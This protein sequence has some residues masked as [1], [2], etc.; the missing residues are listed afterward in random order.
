ML[1]EVH[2]ES[3]VTFARLHGDLDLGSADA[4]RD[5]LDDLSASPTQHIV[6][7]LCDVS[8]VDVMSLSVILGTAD[9]LRES[10]RQLA[11][12]GASASI[13]RLCKVL[14]AE[15]VLAPQIQLS[16]RRIPPA[17]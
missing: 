15:D 16:N 4:L 10:G 12:E 14:N 3:D 6:I 5:L 8:F 17:C 9:A 13:R 2:V 7:D 1:G 11:V